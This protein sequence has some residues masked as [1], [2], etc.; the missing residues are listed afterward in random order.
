G[1]RGEVHVVNVDGERAVDALCDA[2]P[3]VAARIERRWEY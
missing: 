1:R 2:H 3:E